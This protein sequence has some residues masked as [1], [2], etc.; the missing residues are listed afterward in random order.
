MKKVLPLILAGVLPLVMLD[1]QAR[2]GNFY[3]RG[4]ATQEMNVEGF[5]ATHATIPVN[6]RVNALNPKNG[7]EIVVSII[8]RIPPSVDRIID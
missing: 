2:L 3:Q 5:Y 1:A 4:V 7:R 6:S 8:G